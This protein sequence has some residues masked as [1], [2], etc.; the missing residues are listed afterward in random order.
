[1]L[2]NLLNVH[3]GKVYLS[4]KVQEEIKETSIRCSSIVCVAPLY[5]RTVLNVVVLR[6]FLYLNALK[7]LE[8]LNLQGLKIY[9]NVKLL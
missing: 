7:S 6:V 1:M 4:I 9:A 3:V 5:V 8:C 2:K